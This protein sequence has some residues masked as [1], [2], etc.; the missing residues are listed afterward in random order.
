M[1]WRDAATE[2]YRIFQKLTRKL[3][4]AVKCPVRANA[5]Q[6]HLH[7]ATLPPNAQKIKQ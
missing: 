6:L 5:V 1:A 4:R 7:R 3:H 2:K